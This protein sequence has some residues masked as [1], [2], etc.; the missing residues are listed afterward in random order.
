MDLETNAP[1]PRSQPHLHDH[2]LHRKVGG[3]DAHAALKR[4]LLLAAAARVAA[5]RRCR[6]HALA[7]RC[8]RLRASGGCIVIACKR[9]GIVVLALLRLTALLLCPCPCLRVL[10]L[11]VGCRLGCRRLP[12]L[13][14][15]LACCPPLKAACR[16]ARLGRRLPLA[17]ILILAALLALAAAGI[18]LAT[19]AQLLDLRCNAAGARC[20]GLS[21]QRRL[22]ARLGRSQARVEVMPGRAEGSAAMQQAGGAVMDMTVHLP[23]V[24]PGAPRHPL[25]C[26][27]CDACTHLPPPAPPH[28]A[29]RSQPSRRPPRPSQ[30]AAAGRQA[31]RLIKRSWAGRSTRCMLPSAC[32]CHSC[33]SP[34]LHTWLP[35]QRTSGR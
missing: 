2:I 22:C 16:V 13:P 24:P 9:A 6:R 19:Q 31:G 17:I 1:K 21:Q 11:A 4:L 10:L 12:R 8:C 20:T 33:C 25:P 27:V 26:I 35:R 29:G 34:R 14:R 15:R 5:A 18:V 7:R 32:R 23:A 28:S 30:A 3:D